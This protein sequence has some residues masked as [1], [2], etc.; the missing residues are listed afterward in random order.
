MPDQVYDAKYLMN[1]KY[2]GEFDGIEADSDIKRPREED[3]E[4]VRQTRARRT[5]D[6]IG[7][8]LLV[9]AMAISD[10]N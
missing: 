3:P 10:T 1:L 9:D 8:N 2:V 4:F 7:L 6:T 5:E